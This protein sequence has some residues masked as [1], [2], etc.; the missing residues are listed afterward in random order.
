MPGTGWA[1]EIQN[2]QTLAIRKACQEGLKEQRN[3]EVMPNFYHLNF[4]LMDS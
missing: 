4:I 3:R 1:L 2:L